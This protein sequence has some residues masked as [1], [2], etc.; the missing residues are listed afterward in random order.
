MQVCRCA[1][2][3]VCRCAGVKV[4]R[5]R[6]RCAE[7][8]MCM[9]R[10]AQVP[11]WKVGNRKGAEVQM[12]RYAAGA[13]MLQVQVQVQVQVQRCRDAEMQRC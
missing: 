13:D 3:Q 11:R 1:G 10:S 2:V 8:K 7:M 5:C 4:C 6:C 9:G 12:C